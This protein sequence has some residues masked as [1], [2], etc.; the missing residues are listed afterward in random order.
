MEKF[1]D[2]IDKN[3]EYKIVLKKEGNPIYAFVTDADIKFLYLQFPN[4][5]PFFLSIEDVHSMIPSKK[6][7]DF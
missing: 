2:N 3:V 1:L 7:S 4:K 6:G 5:V